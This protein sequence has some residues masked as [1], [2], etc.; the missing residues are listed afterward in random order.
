MNADV[1]IVGLGPTGATLAAL[2]GQRGIRVIVFEK[3]ADLYPLPRAIG[4]DHEVMR[5]MQELGIA[6]AVGKHTAAYRPSEYHGTQG[7]VIKRLDMAPPPFRLGWAPNYVFDQ[8]AFERILRGRLAELPSVQVHLDAEVIAQGQDTVSAWVDV[9]LSGSKLSGS[10]QNSRYTARYLIAC[11]GGASPIRTRL[12]LTLED[13][14][15][16]EPWLVVDAILNDDT[17]ARLPQTQVQYCEPSRPSTFVVLPGNHRRWEIMLLP[18]DSLSPAFPEHELW[19]LLKRWIKPSDGK[20]WRAAAY[21]FHGL[22]A[23]EWRCGRILLAGDAAHMTP[24]FMAQGM[25]QG[26]RD[27]QNLAWKLHLVLEHQAA[28][29]LLDTYGSERRPHVRETTLTAIGLGRVICERDVN[30]ARARDQQLLAEQDGVVR[31]AFRQNMIPD[32]SAGVIAVDTPGAGTLFP[33]PSVHCDS[34]SGRLDDLTGR[35]NAGQNIRVVVLGELDAAVA[36]EFLKMLTPVKGKLVVLGASRNKGEGSARADAGADAGAGAGVTD[37]RTGIHAS[38]IEPV[39]G[40]WLAGLGQLVAIARPDNYVYGTADTPA[41]GVLLLRRLIE[42]V[43]V[44][45]DAAQQIDARS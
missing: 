17:L 32:L 4:L 21:K 34:F 13:L 20:I 7:Q 6:E 1:I 11:D 45:Q 33:Q 37:A 40:D 36:A 43:Y 8:P 25:A 15:F 26:L 5:I 10:N 14:N 29:C 22:L 44:V 18:G 9:H 2:L 19:P 31:T 16:H 42:T 39:I 30:R 28:D 41:A 24:P 38:E 3:L 23:N 35:D 12:G 27:A